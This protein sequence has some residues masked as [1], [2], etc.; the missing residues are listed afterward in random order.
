MDSDD[1][2]IMKIIFKDGT[3]QLIYGGDGPGHPLTALAVDRFRLSA[4]SVEFL[5][6]TRPDGIREVVVTGGDEKPSVYAELPAFEVSSADLAQYA[7]TFQSDEIDAL[8]RFGVETGKL[9]LRRLNNLPGTL[10]MEGPELFKS[11]LGVLRFVRGP[12][13]QITGVT[14]N[15]GR[16]R[17]FR[18]EKGAR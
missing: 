1:D 9:I 7:G 3:L 13:H 11:E 4:A 18:F 8:Y 5:F 2:Q 14:L 10:E 6:R 15:T 16:V 17:N 12:G